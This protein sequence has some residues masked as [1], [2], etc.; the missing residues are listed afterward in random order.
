MDLEPV[1]RGCLV[2]GM[3][4]GSVLQPGLQL[5]IL[6]EPWT[7]V[8][9]G[10]SPVLSLTMSLA[11]PGWTL[12]HRPWDWLACYFVVS[13]SVCRPCYCGLVWVLWDS[14]LS[15]T[16]LPAEGHPQL[17]VHPVS[18]SSPGFIDLWRLV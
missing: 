2:S 17:L 10:F 18:S 1:L 15:V 16:A 9:G 4:L 8:V 13:S 12:L 14:A 6:T 11:L 3:H 7:S 5:W